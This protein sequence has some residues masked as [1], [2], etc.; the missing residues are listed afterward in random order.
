MGQITVMAGPE[1]RRRWSEEERL[2]SKRCF[3]A[4]L[5]VWRSGAD[6]VGHGRWHLNERT[7]HGDWR[8]PGAWPAR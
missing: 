4:T 2:D 5:R 7:G 1:R 3:P 6:A 8:G